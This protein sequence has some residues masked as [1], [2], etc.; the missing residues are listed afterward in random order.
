MAAGKMITGSRNWRPAQVPS[1]KPL[2]TILQRFLQRIR[3]EAMR[4]IKQ[5][6]KL[7]LTQWLNPLVETITPLYAK[8]A[9]ESAMRA[10]RN[11]ATQPQAKALQYRRKAIAN[12]GLGL[13]V[14]NRRVLD[15]VNQAVMDF[16]RSTLETLAGTLAAGLTQLREDLKAGLE[17]GE[18]AYKLTARVQSLFDDP[19]RAFRIAN[20]ETSR[21]VHL[22]EF[23]TV[24]DADVAHQK[25]WLASSDAC[26]LCLS[27]AAGGPVDIDKPF[28]VHAAGNPHYAE[29]MHPPAHPFCFCSVTYVID[30]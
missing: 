28:H 3:P 30:D 4:A 22:G 18:A 14:F 6:R 23:M 13:D 2:A 8:I 29:I 5:G 20:T 17:H 24:A 1:G 7:D 16:C 27:L 21:A 25:I 12:I 10:R 19:L 15:A 9:I 11:I 26:D